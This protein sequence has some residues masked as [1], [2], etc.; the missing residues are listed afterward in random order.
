MRRN[1]CKDCPKHRPGCRR[2]C[3][4]NA[5]EEI[6]VALVD[7]RDPGRDADGFL[8]DQSKRRH[9]RWNLKNLGRR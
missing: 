2:G 4:A 9:E 3:E 5:V 8:A 1:V 7:K 6:M